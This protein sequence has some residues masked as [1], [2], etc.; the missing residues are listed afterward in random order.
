MVV[1]YLNSYNIIVSR[2]VYSVYC[3]LCSVHTCVLCSVKWTVQGAVFMVLAM[4]ILLRLPPSFTLEI[5]SMLVVQCKE[6][7]RGVVEGSYILGHQR[8]SSHQ[9]CCHVIISYRT[10]HH[11]QY[12]H[13]HK[14]HCHHHHY[15]N[16]LH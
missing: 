3:I 4:L 11:Y 13:H 2:I 6:T 9:P 5:G 10:T 16:P 15:H 8:S 12:P 1:S 14:H 7:K